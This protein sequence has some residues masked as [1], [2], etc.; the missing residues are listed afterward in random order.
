MIMTTCRRFALAALA[1]L[2]VGTVSRAA[3]PAKPN[4]LIILADDMG[5]S[6][7]GC[8]GGEIETPNLDRLAEGR[9]AVH[10]V[11][12]HGPLLAVAGAHC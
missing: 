2:T 11:L 4:I 6:D 5:Y 10:A 8:Y 7:A 12:Q 3:A 9:P 1:V